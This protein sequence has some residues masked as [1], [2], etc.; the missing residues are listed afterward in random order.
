MPRIEG[1]YAMTDWKEE[2]VLDGESDRKITRVHAG[3]TWHGPIEG[4]AETV[5]LIAYLDKTGVPFSGF[6][7]FAG[8]WGDVEGSFTIAESGLADAAAAT[9][10]WLVVEGSGTGGFA[11]ITG[12]GGFRA[13]EGLTFAFTLDFT[14]PAAS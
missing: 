8:R 5:Y 14:L 3:G 13:D 7:R 12:T 9:S 2:P 4:K 11:G 1:T 6:L 10:E